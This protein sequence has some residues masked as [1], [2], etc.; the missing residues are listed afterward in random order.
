[1]QRPS[2]DYKKGCHT[3]NTKG[4]SLAPARSCEGVVQHL[5]PI[6]SG[7]HHHPVVVG[8]EAVHT[9]QQ[10][11]QRLLR[12]IVALLVFVTEQEQPNREGIIRREG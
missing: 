1:M 11:V 3:V 8:V 5:V 4:L 2:T 10:L 9:C 6:R 12:L 7:Y